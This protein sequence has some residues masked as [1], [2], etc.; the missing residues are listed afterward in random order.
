MNPATG[1]T[2]RSP[3][4]E[5]A[6]ADLVQLLAKGVGRHESA[7]A[8][9]V[10]L[11][12][13]VVVQQLLEA[14]QAE[15]LGS[16][17]RYGRRVGGQRGSRNG[18]ERIRLH[19]EEGV[20]EV[21]VPQVRNV[22]GPY[23][24]KI[25]RNIDDDSDVLDRIVLAAYA[26]WLS[27]AGLGGSFEEVINDYWVSRS[28]TARIIRQFAADHQAF[29]DRDLSG[30]SVEHLFCDVIF[31]SPKRHRSDQALLVA[32][33]TDTTGRKHL[34]HLAVGNKTSETDWNS[35]LRNLFE[36]NMLTPKTVTTNGTPGMIKAVGT[37][38]PETVRFRH[39][40]DRPT[41]RVTG[42]A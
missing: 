10:K 33:A 21:N 20:I 8:E 6:R 2:R 41:E 18:Y 32:W 40:F 39:W 15:F 11:T 7:V 3:P 27:S 24:S 13:R 34:L 14:E 38:F 29:I 16:R 37:V 36:R 30:I 22:G 17:G 31:D 1:R 35:L 19:T 26:R 25:M 5:R 28:E 23:R 12:I 42:I 9:F 4:S